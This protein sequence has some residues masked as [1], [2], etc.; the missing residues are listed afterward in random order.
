VKINVLDRFKDYDKDNCWQYQIRVDNLE[1]DLIEIGLM[2][3]EAKKLKISDFEFVYVPKEN[4]KTCQAVVTFIKRNEWLG[5]LPTRPTHRF[6]A[7][8][9]GVM[10][11][12]VVMATPNAF[13]H[14]LGPGTKDLEKLI[15][16]GACISWSPKNLASALIM[17]GVKWMVANT[18]FRLFTAYS[19]PEAK[20]LGTIYQACN[21]MYLG[22]KNGGSRVYFDPSTPHLGWIS[23][24]TFRRKR[25]YKRYAQNLGIEWQKEWEKPTY[26]IDWSKVPDEYEAQI[27]QASKDYLP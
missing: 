16:R 7:Y 2:D 12:V 1:E 19:D 6:V 10:A 4:K 13:S 17:Y 18:Q 3:V 21:F 20:E 5:K 14:L 8:Y 11:G 24:R 9:K 23:D 26:G 27:R 25:Y 22:Q 15:S